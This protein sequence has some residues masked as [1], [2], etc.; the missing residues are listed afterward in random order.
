M[1]VAGMAAC[2]KNH[3]KPNEGLTGTWLWTEQR[4]DPGDGSGTWRQVETIAK[5]FITFEG[6][7]TYKDS[8]S[9]TYN[10]YTYKQDTV[11]LYSTHSAD[12]FKLSVQE[13]NSGTLSY[14]FVYPW[15]C[16]GPSGEK[17]KRIID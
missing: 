2:T 17:F 11:T 8:R 15:Y 10:R 9:A 4:A 13:L 6:N 14:Y 5:A 1:L 7:G 16:G 12:T 3:N